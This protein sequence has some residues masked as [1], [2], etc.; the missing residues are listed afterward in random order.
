M[1]TQPLKVHRSWI[2]CAGLIAVCA[3]AAKTFAERA[4]EDRRGATHV[5]LGTVAGVYARE[6]QGT[7][8]YLVELVVEKIEKGEGFKPGETF[9]VGCYLWIPDYYKG[10]KLSKEEEERLAFRGGDYSGVPKEGERVRVYAKH[11]AIYANGRPGKYSG[12]FPDWFDV[13]QDK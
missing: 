13:L 4:P 9:Y 1:H 12:V 11:D 3:L 8:H 5:I 6:E 10:K 2:L 7:C